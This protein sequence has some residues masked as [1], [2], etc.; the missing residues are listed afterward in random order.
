MTPSFN[1]LKKRGGYYALFETCAGLFNH[2][3]IFQAHMAQ[4]I[5][6]RN[7]NVNVI[8]AHLSIFSG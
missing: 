5:K 6:E 3:L 7:N 4:V 1:S 2:L 8:A